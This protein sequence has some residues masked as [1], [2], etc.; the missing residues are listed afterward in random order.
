MCV[1]S[2]KIWYS[3]YV[4]N[5]EQGLSKT[6]ACTQMFKPNLVGITALTGSKAFFDT[7][8]LMNR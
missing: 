8:L 7:C 5:L 6:L 3:K 2:W 1:I 4:R